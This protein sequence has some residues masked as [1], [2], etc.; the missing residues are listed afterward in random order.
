MPTNIKFHINIESKKT[1]IGNNSGF[2]FY[3]Q[4]QPMFYNILKLPILKFF[5][6]I[7][8]NIFNKKQKLYQLIF[9]KI[10]K[11]FIIKLFITI[12]INIFDTKQNLY[13]PILYNI[14][15][16]SILML[17]IILKN[18]IAIFQSILIKK[19][20][21]SSK[22]S[23]IKCKTSQIKVRIIIIVTNIGHKQL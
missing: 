11:L 7:K 16:L 9:Y 15:K 23:F 21:L 20:I 1:Y 2:I 3:K 14:F 12:G 17:F 6:S 8:I 22:L 13:Y 19:T 5:I 10:S 4:H 18:K